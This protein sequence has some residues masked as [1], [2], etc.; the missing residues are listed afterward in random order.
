MAALAGCWL[1]FFL[2]FFGIILFFG[3]AASQFGNMKNG[4][5]SSIDK[6]SWL[7]I[8]LSASVTER[9][10]PN[11]QFAALFGNDDQTLPLDIL[12]ASIK[13]AATDNDID[14]IYLQCGG[15]GAG[16]AQSQ[17][18]ID[19]LKQFKQTDKWIIASGESITQGDYFIASV[20]DSIFINPVGM[21][22]IHGLAASTTFFK[23]FLDKVGVNV[24]V[25]KVGTF[26]SAVEPYM[27]TSMSDA[28]RLQQEVF[29]GRMWKNI[30]SQMAANRKTTL[31]KINTVAD[32]S[33]YAQPVDY[34]IANRLVDRALYNH[35]LD[36][37]L[38]QMSEQTD[39]PILVSLADYAA[40]RK[41]APFSKKG[42]K[43]IVVLYAV[44]SITDS[45]GDGI[46]GATLVPQIINLAD[47][48]S[49]DGLILRVNSG[50]GSAYASE[51][52]WEAL[53]TFKQKRGVPFYVSMSDYAASGGY[54]ISC[55]ADKIFAQPL[56]LTGSIG[57]FGMIPEA[58]Q[59][60]N[61]KLAIHTETV[62]TNPTGQFPS[63][64]SPMTPTQRRAM[65]GY[66]NRGY[67]L[68][69]SRVAQGRDLPIDSVKAIAEGRVWDGATALEIGLVDQLGGLDDAIEAMTLE[70]GVESCKVVVEPNIEF[71]FWSQLTAKVPHIKAAILKSELGAA[72]PYFMQL[73]E[74]AE[75]QPLQA[76]IELTIDN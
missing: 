53:E 45:D 10:N 52:I 35:Q 67:E 14:G 13:K 2:A 1:S 4:A 68:F 32:S 29:L 48:D 15:G 11:D 26:K 57:I 66:V 8:D 21:L 54:Y 19:A 65:Q 63:L 22:D 59:L 36:A 18:I 27:L 42:K 50:G 37:T 33:C 30:A 62:A 46:V 3:M 44:G 70:L 41:V 28:N 24:Q 55:G 61:D 56:T 7:W 38:A 74:A 39:K 69:T 23:G 17:E 43:K 58:S 25:V 31:A 60:L 73:K 16:M 72:Y 40:V 51:Q 75:M 71:D 5:P 20:A 76:R 49:V 64:M 9:E 6:H 47:D 34:Y 12:I